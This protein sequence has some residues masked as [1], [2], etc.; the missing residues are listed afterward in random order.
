MNE[1]AKRRLTESRLTAAV[2]CGGC[3]GK[4]LRKKEKR[5]RK[6]PHGHVLGTV[7]PGFRSCNSPWLRLSEKPWD[8]KPLR[9]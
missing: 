1:Q 4:G 6:K 5:E 2:G 8:P 9:R 7:L 3:V